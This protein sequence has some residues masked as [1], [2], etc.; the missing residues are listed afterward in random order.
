LKSDRPGLRAA[1]AAGPPQIEAESSPRPSGDGQWLLSPSKQDPTKTN[2]DEIYGNAEGK[3]MNGGQ[4][5]LT[6][7]LMLFKDLKAR[8]AEDKACIPERRWENIDQHIAHIVEMKEQARLQR[9]ESLQQEKDLSRE[10]SR[11]SRQRRKEQPSDGCSCCVR[12]PRSRGGTSPASPGP[13][14]A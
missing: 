11:L 10:A 1:A 14:S 6:D 7:A 3:M 4:D 9:V 12:S 5:E 8:A 2:F 13:A